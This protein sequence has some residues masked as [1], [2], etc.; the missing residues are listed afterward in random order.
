M[1]A[2]PNS[3]TLHDRAVNTFEPESW[4]IRHFSQSNPRGAGEGN[5]PA[6][7]RRVADTLEGLGPAEVM[8][9]VRNRRD[10]VRLLEPPGTAS[11]TRRGIS[12]V[13]GEGTCRAS[14]NDGGR[15]GSPCG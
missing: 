14:R 11:Y 7:L 2:G 9:L 4:T 10:H 15:R 13:P 12:S 5:V 8:D 6:L 3:P 1:I